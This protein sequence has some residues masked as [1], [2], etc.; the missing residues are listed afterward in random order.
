MAF[1]FVLRQFERHEP[2]E[3]GMRGFVERNI[4]TAIERLLG[5]AGGQRRQR[6][7]MFCDLRRLSEKLGMRAP[8]LRHADS[9]RLIGSERAT[10]RPATCPALSPSPSP[11]P[12]PP[13]PR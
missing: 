13:P 2:I 9:I 12:P 6:S 10:S 1:G 3:I 4:Q 5:D 8:P 7:D 11:P